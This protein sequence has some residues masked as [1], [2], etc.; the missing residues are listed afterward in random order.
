MINRITLIYQACCV[1]ICWMGGWI[2]Y[3]QNTSLWIGADHVPNS[4]R[5]NNSSVWTTASQTGDRLVSIDTLNTSGSADITGVGRGC[6]FIFDWL[7]NYSYIFLCLR[8][9]GHNLVRYF[10]KFEVQTSFFFDIWNMK[11]NSKITYSFR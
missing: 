3:C 11:A 6:V 4:W 8:L 10:I 2:G 1:D 5:N 7:S 9:L